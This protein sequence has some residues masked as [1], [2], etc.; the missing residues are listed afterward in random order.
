MRLKFLLTFGFITV[1][2]LVLANAVVAQEEPPPPYT[3]AENPFPWSDTPVQETGEGIYQSCIGCH[4]VDGG[5]IAE[6]DFSA[7]GFAQSLEERPDYYFWI[8][9][10]GRL[11]K[12]MPPF[13][14]SLSEEQR[15]QV[16]TY[17]WS[18]G[19]AAPPEVPPPAKPPA[20][21]ENVSLL[22]TAPEQARFGQSLTLSATLRDADGEP[23]DGATVKF[24][25]RT[26]FFASGLMEIGKALTTEDGVA[27]FEYAPQQTGDIEVAAHYETIEV[28]ATLTVAESDEVFYQP[29]AGIHLPSPGEDVLVGPE[30]ARE[31]EE[32]G[33]A[34][35]TASLLAPGSGG[36]DSAHLGNLLPCYVPGVSY[37]DSQ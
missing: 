29:E 35:M 13:K 6:S 15:W 7:E 34:P 18:L 2:L 27:L 31:L 21:L 37:S 4:G 22:L 28:T 16:L 19:K 5:N 26:D 12:G 36:N 25:V 10:E 8:L 17:L 14:S 33:R 20:E 1:F 9:S 23:I 30:S 24:F 11:D 3:G 32:M